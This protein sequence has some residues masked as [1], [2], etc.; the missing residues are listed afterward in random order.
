MISEMLFCCSLECRGTATASHRQQPTHSRWRKGD[1]NVTGGLNELV[2]PTLLPLG[3]FPT[4]ALAHC[5]LL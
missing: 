5:R 1:F 3:D 2:T 4:S